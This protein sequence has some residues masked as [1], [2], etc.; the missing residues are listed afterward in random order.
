[1]R[2]ADWLRAEPRRV[3]LAGWLACAALAAAFLAPAI[4]KGG[5]GPG[6]MLLG[7]TPWGLY[8]DQFPA[9]RGVANPQL[10]VIQQYFPWR[11][12][13][14]ATLRGGVLPLWNPHEYCG[15]PFVGNVLS[16]VYYPFTWLALWLPIGRFFLLSAWFHLTLLG[17]GM[18]LL[19]RAHGLR[20]QGAL[21]GAGA[22]MLNG[23]VIGW[24]AYANASQWTYA[25]L[26]L[27]CWSWHRAWAAQ[28]P[29]RLWLPAGCLALSV[30]GGHLQFTFY[31]GLAWAVYALVHVLG[32]SAYPLLAKEGAGGSDGNPLLAKEGAGGGPVHR[33]DCPSTGSH[34]NPLLSKERGP[35]RRPSAR[36]LGDLLCYVAAPAALAGLVAAVQVLPALELIFASGRTGGSYADL[37]GAGFPVRNLIVLLAPWFYGHNALQFQGAPVAGFWGPCGNGIEASVSA[38][39]AATWLAVTALCR[40]RDRAVTAFAVIALVGLLLALR[41]PL[42]WLFWRCVPGF[43]G[44]RGLSRAFCVWGFGVAA[45]CGIGVDALLDPCDDRRARA[46]LAAGCMV[47]TLA[48]FVAAWVAEALR[49]TAPDSLTSMVGPRLGY[50]MPATLW[51]VAA[52]GAVALAV[53]RGRRAAWVALVPMVE[54]FRLGSGMHPG[55]DPRVYFFDTPET[56]LLQRQT[57]PARFVGVAAGGS[58]AFLDWMPMNTPMAYGLSSP[59]GSESLSYGRYRALLSTFCP[60][61]WTPALDSPLLSLVGVRWILSR[62]DLEGRH[63]L[64]RVGGERCAV[65]ENPRALP[66]VFAA[67]RWE[68]CSA[69]DAIARLR[70]P[71]VD[72]RV[73]FLPENAPAPTPGVT[74]SREASFYYE[75][76][77]PQRWVARG[78]PQRETM[79]VLTET[80]GPGWRALVNGAP[81]RVWLADAVFQAVEVPPGEAVVRWF[82]APS[83]VRVGTFLALVGLALLAAWPGGWLVEE[84]RR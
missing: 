61:P 67:S 64:R 52:S 19:L 46:R 47:V 6:D 41:T 74:N 73:P 56:K 4:L 9:V 77:S 8:R 49:T 22:L 75:R 80:L 23:F 84:G 25:W 17:G 18:W 12:F 24:L 20:W 26:P 27:L 33:A 54:L 28:R 69:T 59:T 48:A 36:L 81:R 82:Y 31:V 34:P 5:F 43:S 1:M 38:G 29:G 79:L 21:A 78:R 37:R 55:V 66:L 7:M 3:T 14:A 83:S 60:E 10:D 45:L 53:G 70:S 13:A 50:G 40:R 30:L 39:A 57:P 16:A 15:Q 58:P 71:E 32:S 63:G 68:R 11:L 65:Y 51:A 62:A 42:Y 44:L 35:D 76:S 72:L 2:A